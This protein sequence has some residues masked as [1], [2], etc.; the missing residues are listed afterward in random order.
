MMIVKRTFRF[1]GRR[2]INF[3]NQTQKHWMGE[4]SPIS[5]WF[6]AFLLSDFVVLF[7]KNVDR[8]VMPIVNCVI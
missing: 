3:Q 4:L 7:R 5:A 8:I 2:E 1:D 6:D